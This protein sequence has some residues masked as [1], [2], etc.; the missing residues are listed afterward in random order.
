VLLIIQGPKTRLGR[1]F[2][3]LP[4]I[5][6]QDRAL[7]ARDRKDFDSLKKLFPDV[8]ILRAW[9][10]AC[11]LPEASEVAVLCFALGPVHVVAPALSKDLEGAFADLSFIQTALALYSPQPVHVVYLSSVLALAPRGSRRYYAGWKLM[12]EG[13]LDAWVAGSRGAS[14]S[15]VYPGRLVETGTGLSRCLH[16]RYEKVAAQL[17]EMVLARRVCRRKVIGWDSRI[18][19]FLRGLTLSRMV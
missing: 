12:V 19:L 9:D 10:P 13:T 17:G 6:A 2:L 1:A 18:L 3:A 16:T 4:Q 11:E 8:K 7:I 14:L 5:Q 15:V